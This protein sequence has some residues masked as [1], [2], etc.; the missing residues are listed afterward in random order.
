MGA[1]ANSA[2]FLHKLKFYIFHF[3]C[4]KTH[5]VRIPAGFIFYFK[6]LHS[7]FMIKIIEKVLIREFSE[8]IKMRRDLSSFNSAHFIPNRI[9]IV[10]LNINLVLFKK[11]LSS[12]FKY[13]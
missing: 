2:L 4:R 5:F 8:K 10:H 9:D 3:K 12:L 1:W 13:I 11:S 6:A 7:H